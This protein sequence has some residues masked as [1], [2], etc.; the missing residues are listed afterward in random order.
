MFWYKISLFILIISARPHFLK[1][2]KTK[3]IIIAVF[4]SIF[5]LSFLISG[6]TSYDQNPC[7]KCTLCYLLNALR[8]AAVTG[9]ATSQLPVFSELVCGLLR[10]PWATQLFVKEGGIFRFYSMSDWLLCRSTF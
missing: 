7:S 3:T 8:K 4:S 5:S 2:N 1:Q 6:N 10:V 9:W